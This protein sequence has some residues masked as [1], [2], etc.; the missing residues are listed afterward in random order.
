MPYTAAM[1]LAKVMITVFYLDRLLSAASID[2][3]R[4]RPLR[5][6]EGNLPVRRQPDEAPDHGYPVGAGQR[7]DHVHQVRLCEPSYNIGY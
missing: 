3:G 4:Q 5:V 2:L 6:E 1:T 7:H